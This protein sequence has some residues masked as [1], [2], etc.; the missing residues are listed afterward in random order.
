MFL[1]VE[2]VT[3]SSAT[4]SERER[5][6]FSNTEVLATLQVSREW[7]HS[8]RVK[9]LRHHAKDG[10][11]GEPLEH[12]G[13]R[14]K[15]INRYVVS[16]IHF[17]SYRDCL[18]SRQIGLPLILEVITFSQVMSLHVPTRQLHTTCIRKNWID[19][20]SCGKAYNEVKRKY[21]LG[22]WCTGNDVSQEQTVPHSFDK[23]QYA[24]KRYF[25]FLFKSNVFG[26]MILATKCNAEDECV[27][28]C[29]IL[30]VPRFLDYMYISSVVTGFRMLRNV[31]QGLGL[32]IVFIWL[33]RTRT[34]CELLWTW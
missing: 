26:V 9:V 25:F 13:H 23:K 5:T 31:M 3:S 10:S 28:L 2:Y 20:L 22:Q 8:G 27:T 14:N 16:V 18:N 1:C 6:L 19:E 4:V 29:N 11:D 34:S 33:I 32:A 7:R 17:P 24:Q 15:K 30:E 12:N 21:C